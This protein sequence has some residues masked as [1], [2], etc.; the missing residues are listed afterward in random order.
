QIICNLDKDFRFRAEIEIGKGRGYVPAEKNKKPE[1][2]ALGT[3]AIDSLYSP[4]VR[5]RYN[6]G[7][8]RLGEA[9]EMDSLAIEIWTDGRITP[10][11][12]LEKSA[13]IIRDHLVP[14][15]GKEALVE[16][17]SNELTEEEEK[18]L[19]IL[20]T[21]VD[22]MELS[23]RSQ[24]CLKNANIKLL[25]ELCLKTEAKMLKYRNFGRISLEEVKE[26]LSSYGLNLG[27]SFPE[28]ITTAIE[29]E[30]KKVKEI[31]K[32]EDN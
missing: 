6:V 28:K 12:A 9:T 29:N 13:E 19:K 3:I 11:E 24:N 7:I 22:E 27:M 30:A 25:G 15:L 17:I 16:K 23:V 32:S 8:A 21:K 20:T 18:L 14:F 2:Q 4:V 5:V 10:K 31:F 26:K 1:Q